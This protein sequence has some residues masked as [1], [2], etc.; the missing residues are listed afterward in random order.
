MQMVESTVKV[1][2]ITGIYYT[3]LHITLKLNRLTDNVFSSVSFKSIPA[4]PIFKGET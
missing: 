1:N 2:E 3:I 4:F